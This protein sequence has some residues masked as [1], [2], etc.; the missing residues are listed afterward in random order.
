MNSRQMSQ[1]GKILLIVGIVFVAYFVIRIIAQGTSFIS[2]NFPLSEKWRVH[3]GEDVTS[4]SITDDQIVLVRT[5][6]KLY[7]LD[8]KL[9]NII[10]Q[11]NVGGTLLDLPV[12]TKN[13]IVF[14]SNLNDILALNELDGKVLWK[15]T[16]T[17]APEV[18]T[19]LKGVVAVA[20]IPSLKMYQAATGAFLWETPACRNQIQAYFYKSTVYIFC[21]GIKALGVFFGGYIW[22]TVE[23]DRPYAEAFDGATMYSSADNRNVIAYDLEKRVQLWSTPLSNDRVEEFK[24]VDQFLFLTDQ[25]QFCALRRNDGKLLWCAHKILDPQNPVGV[26]NVVY[27]LGALQKTIRAYD[28]LTGVQIGQ[29]TWTNL[30]LGFLAMYRHLMVSS[31]DLLIFGYG[32]EVF[33]FG[34]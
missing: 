2:E 12:V 11:Q 20:D 18:V 8:K 14:L 22:E 24:I 33:A 29:L 16:F 19:V 28:P 3:L 32:Q 1:H 7:A 13:N 23:D 31:D 4:V 30:N 6:S 27:I 34:K 17:Y 26:G 25:H 5:W 15:Q 21:Y 10:W 9:G